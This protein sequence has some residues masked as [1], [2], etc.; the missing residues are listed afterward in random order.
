MTLHSRWGELLKDE[1]YSIKNILDFDRSSFWYKY[2]LLTY[3][4]TS[5]NRF[6]LEQLTGLQLVKK[7]HAFYGTHRFITAFTSARHLSLSWIRSTQS[8]PPYPTTRKFILILS[9]HLHLGLPSG[10]FTSGF[11]TKIVYTSLPLPQPSYMPRPSHSDTSTIKTK[12]LWRW[13]WVAWNKGQSIFDLLFS[14]RMA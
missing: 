1:Y 11:P 13:K 2:N 3:F 14:A 6:L 4:I 9:Y 12:M 5:W 10:L 7:F 8:I